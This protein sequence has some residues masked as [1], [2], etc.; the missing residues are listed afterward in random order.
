MLLQQDAIHL[1][2]SLEYYSL[3]GG[4]GL[5]KHEENGQLSSNQGPPDYSVPA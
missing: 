1:A 4:E 5:N 2:K 3:G